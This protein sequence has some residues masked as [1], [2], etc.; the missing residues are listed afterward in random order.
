MR[1]Q[2]PPSPRSRYQTQER[3][4][5]TWISVKTGAEE[6]GDEEDGERDGETPRVATVESIRMGRGRAPPRGKRGPP[7]LYT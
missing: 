7:G 6:E 1:S 2:T 3:H 4:K 5:T